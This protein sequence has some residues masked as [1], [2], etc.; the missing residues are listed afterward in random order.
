MWLIA[1]LLAFA[2]PSDAALYKWVDAEGN[3][4]YSDQPPPAG[5]GEAKTMEAPRAPRAGRTKSAPNA[6]AGSGEAAGQAGA[7]EAA[8]PA[9][10]AVK[11]GTPKSIAEQEMEFRKRRLEA[12]EAEAKA[13]KDAQEAAEKKRSCEQAQ[14]RVAAF[15]RGGRIT[16][17]DAS[18]E[19]VFLNDDEIGR[20]L[21]DARRAA[22]S[23]CK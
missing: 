6:D 10:Q 8:A 2:L 1:G 12:A 22:D 3:V 17:Y 11:P 16:R 9:G 15:E 18:G 4:H 7:R 14:R 20:E 21:V 5:A 13:Q 19:Q 23:W